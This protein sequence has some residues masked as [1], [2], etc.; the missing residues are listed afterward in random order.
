M[1]RKLDVI[2]I[3]M[4]YWFNYNCIV[5]ALLFI[6]SRYQLSVI[7]KLEYLNM[8]LSYFVSIE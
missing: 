4:S 6:I 3:M 7:V 8:K 2:S 5:C 1:N